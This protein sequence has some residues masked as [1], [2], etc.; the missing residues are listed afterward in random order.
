[1]P[2]SAS[3]KKPQRRKAEEFFYLDQED[4]RQDSG[5]HE[6]ILEDGDQDAAHAV[7]REVMARLGLSDAEIE[8]LVGPKSGE[9]AFQG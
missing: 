8:A 1:M 5:L 9:R 3:R 6:P 2:T 4:S 7:S